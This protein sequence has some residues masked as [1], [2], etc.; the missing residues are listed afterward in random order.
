MLL[1]TVKF[2]HYDVEEDASPK[3]LFINKDITITGDTEEAT[4]LTRTTIQ[5]GAD[6]TFKN[7]HLEMVTSGGRST[8]IY[9]AGHTLVLDG[10]NTKLGTNSLQDDIRPYISGG[11][12]KGTDG[13]LGD[14]AVIKVIHPTDQTRAFGDICRRLLEEQQDACGHRT[15]W[16][17]SRYGDPHSRSGRIWPGGRCV[18]QAG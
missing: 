16:K 12:Y 18:G 15:G 17:I 5:L 3:P 10:V 8:T 14:H 11:A 2:T 13:I 4:L 1:G 9:A 6:V 7:M